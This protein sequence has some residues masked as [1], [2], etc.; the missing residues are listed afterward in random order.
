MQGNVKKYPDRG[1]KSIRTVGSKECQG[2]QRRRGGQEGNERQC[3]HS[4]GRPGLRE[5]RNLLQANVLME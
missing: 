3:D 1:L 4:L 5:T 2:Q